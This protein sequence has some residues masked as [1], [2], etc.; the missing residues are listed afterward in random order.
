MPS[1]RYNSKHSYGHQ[2][3]P[4]VRHSLGGIHGALPVTIEL[5]GTQI[6]GEAE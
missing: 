6:V 3:L 4:R 1:S 5:L 2:A